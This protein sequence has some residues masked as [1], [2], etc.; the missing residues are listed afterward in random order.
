MLFFAFVSNTIAKLEKK[1]KVLQVLDNFYPF[2][3]DF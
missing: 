1:T 3:A 2:L